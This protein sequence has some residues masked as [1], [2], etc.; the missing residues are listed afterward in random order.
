MHDKLELQHKND[1]DVSI[2]VSWPMT[3]WLWVWKWLHSCSMH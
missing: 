1:P 2:W 3:V